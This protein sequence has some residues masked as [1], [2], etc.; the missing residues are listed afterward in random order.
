M[1]TKRTTIKDI[2]EDVGVS[3][4]L[5]SFVMNKK[6]KLHRV[7]EDMTAK[8]LEAAKRLDYQPNNAARSLRNG[9]TRT[10]GV[11]VSDI[12]NSFF[13]DIAR[14]IEDSAYKN[15]YTVIFGSSDENVQ[16]MDNLIQVLINKGVDGLIVVPCQGNSKVIAEI[17][18]SNLPIVLLDR[19]IPD[20]EIS[21]VGLNNRKATM[22]AIEHLVERGYSRISMVSYDMELTNVKE[23]EN[24]YT[25]AM[26]KAGLKENI[27]IHK[28]GFHNISDD[29]VA[30]LKKMRAKSTEAIVFGTNTLTTKGLKHLRNMNINVP[31]DMAIVG[32]DNSE[33]FELFYTSIT[34][35]NQPIE[36]IG[37]EA[38]NMIIKLIEEREKVKHCTIILDP[39]L[40]EGESSASK[41]ITINQLVNV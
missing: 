15:N 19:Y 31:H 40:V 10:V 7:S 38:F 21:Y 36:Q 16:K 28:I 6:E 27:D 5:V 23:R 20:S 4:A 37:T 22:R 32:F 17:E 39:E 3:I 9:R 33:A 35:I 13:A 11:I 8:I 25:T 30:A 29:V 34:Y 1:K 26:N 2:A 14:C 24:G 12:S 41:Q 18:R